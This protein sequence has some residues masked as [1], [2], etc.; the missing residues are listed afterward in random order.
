MDIELESVLEK[1]KI[2]TEKILVCTR[3][4]EFFSLNN[5]L[6]MTC[7][8]HPGTMLDLSSIKY[9]LSVFDCCFAQ[10]TDDFSMRNG[11]TPCVHTTE[12]ERHG[13]VYLV[14]ILASTLEPRMQDAIAKKRYKSM[15]GKVDNFEEFERL[16]KVNRKY[17]SD[18]E[19]CKAVKESMKEYE[20]MSIDSLG[21]E[22][23]GD[24]YVAVTQKK[25]NSRNRDLKR[26]SKTETSLTKTSRYVFLSSSLA[27][28]K[29][30]IQF[31]YTMLLSQYS[32]NDKENI[33]KLL[34]EAHQRK[35]K[36]SENYHYVTDL[37]QMVVTI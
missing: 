32:G 37:L 2:E 12:K 25:Y 26:P 5:C 21:R 20:A 13:K 27:V 35:S 31:N 3:C 34:L 11:C 15:L 10:R 7:S 8:H 22:S 24:D 19:W 1:E 14:P 16:C 30:Q 23:D 18:T 33:R 17:A 29:T 6:E 36:C 4:Q 28:E 9:G